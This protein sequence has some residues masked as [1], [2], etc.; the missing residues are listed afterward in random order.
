MSIPRNTIM[1]VN[2]IMTLIPYIL[3]FIIGHSSW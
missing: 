2:N 3:E 1:N